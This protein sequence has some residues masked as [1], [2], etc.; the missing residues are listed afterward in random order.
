MLIFLG[1]VG[2][3]SSIVLLSYALR[4]EIIPSRI[5]RICVNQ[6]V[7][8]W[9]GILVATMCHCHLNL[10]VDHISVKYM[11][12]DGVLLNQT[13]H[14]ER[15]KPAK[16]PLIFIS[17]TDYSVN[18]VSI[19][20]R[21]AQALF[22][23]RSKVKWIVVVLPLKNNNQIVMHNGAMSGDKSRRYF[24]NLR[25]ILARFGV[26]FVLL[27]SNGEN[28]RNASQWNGYRWPEISNRIVQGYLT[29]LLWALKNLSSGVVMLGEMEYV[30]EATLFE[31]VINDSFMLYVPF[32]LAHLLNFATHNM[33]LGKT[34]KA[35][36][37]PVGP[38]KYGAS[39]STP[40]FTLSL[41]SKRNVE[42]STTIGHFDG[43]VLRLGALL[44]Q[45][46]AFAID[47]NYLRYV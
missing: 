42:Q 6:L 2:A 23:A 24:K 16:T 25:S 21:T 43:T 3:I 30:Y 13:S 31:E 36:C 41:N 1:T 11:E 19:L 5:R 47:L 27:P 37:W 15:L 7:S 20:A 26:P 44:L 46:G 33:Q 17:T 29:G 35:S 39:V 22:K 9:F 14:F 10:R 8:I 12:S 28:L 45:R 34:E 40:I 38:G 4:K 32:R 18:Q